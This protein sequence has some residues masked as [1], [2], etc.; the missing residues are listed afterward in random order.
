[1][2]TSRL[3]QIGSLMLLMA[4][5]TNCQAGFVVDASP[6]LVGVTSSANVTVSATVRL[7][8]SSV[9]AEE[10]LVWQ[11][12]LSIVP[13]PSAM[14]AV[15]ISGINQPLDYVLK[16]VSI[17]GPTLAFGSTVPSA[18][19][20]LADAS[21]A[22]SGG[23]VPPGGTGSLLGLTIAIPAGAS[24]SYRLEMT[25]F[26]AD[27]D[28]ASMWLGSSSPFPVPYDNAGPGAG[29][30]PR[31]L[32]TINVQAVPEPSGQVLILCC[33]TAASVVNRIS[34]RW[35]RGGQAR[36]SRLFTRR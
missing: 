12:G 33:A 10:L 1:M 20:V 24:G 8:N 21:A 5:R 28:K 30:G 29:S 35:A 3:M 7:T 14:G 31:T 2:K 11:A 13:A 6:S 27:P 16:D 32:M 23:A 4:V 26:D 18:F 22:L 25:P 15:T 19:V 36:R 9:G 17:F 34:S